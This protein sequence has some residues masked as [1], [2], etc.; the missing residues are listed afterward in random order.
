MYKMLFF[1]LLCFNF[2]PLLAQDNAQLKNSYANRPIRMILPQPA[3]GS[4]DTNARAISETFGAF[5]GQNIVID[6]RGAANGIIAGEIFM[7]SPADG[8]TILFAS[9]SLITNQAINK[10][11][12]FDALRDFIPV[13]Q[14][15]K[16]FGYIV[17]VN[18]QT[19]VTTLKELIELSKR[20]Q[21][22]YGSGGIG[23]A[24]HLGVELINIRSGAKLFHVPY[25]GLSPIIPAIMNNEIQVTL[26]PPLTIMQHI[27]N[28]KLIP[29]AYTGAK[30]WE[31]LSEVPTMME[32]GVKNCVYEPGG[33]GIF[34]PA[35]TPMNIV[36]Q[37][38]TAIVYTIN[39]PKI[40]E[41]LIRGGYTPIGS[42]PTEFRKYL[43]NDFKRITE[44]VKIAKIEKN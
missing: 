20:K 36:K 33:H 43:E 15:A 18:P 14:V 23:N 29:L 38:H 13:T 4:A 12:P 11:I 3:G 8:H 17:L 21:I 41:Y 6:N 2:A 35:G 26:A 34:V 32:A 39:A 40:S 28:G 19:G 44:I 9:G 30:R 22:N 7:K 5:L 25:K 24:L 1:L 27:R 31:G 16:T 10:N 37:I 42:T